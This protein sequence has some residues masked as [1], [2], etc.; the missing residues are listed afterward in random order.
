MAGQATSDFLAK[1]I[2]A[3]NNIVTFRLLSRQLSIH[4]AEAK[5]E[6]EL[7]YDAAKLAKDPVF[8]TYILTGT[9]ALQ[10]KQETSSCGGS[11][12]QVSRRLVVLAGE[13]ELEV[14]KSRFADGPSQ[15]VYSLSPVPLKDHGLLT[16]VADRVRLLDIQRGQSHAAQVG[17]LLSEE[18]PWSGVS[19]SKSQRATKKDTLAP[20]NAKKIDQALKPKPSIDTAQPVAT[21]DTGR[22]SALNF[23][24]SKKPASESKP[25]EPAPSKTKPPTKK[26]PEEATTK[27]KSSRPEHPKESFKPPST[28]SSKGSAPDPPK[29]AAV[30]GKSKRVLD[31]SDEDEP[32]L[33]RSKPALKRKKNRST[34]DDDEEAVEQRSTTSLRAMM[35]IDDDDVVNGRS[36]REAT[37]EHVPSARETAAAAKAAK[38]EASK[39]VDQKER[40]SRKRVPKGKK[41]VMKT[42][43]VK[44]AKGFL[45]TEDYS[46][47]EDADPA[48]ADKADNTDAQSE[49]D[50]GEDIDVDV[51]GRILPKKPASKPTTSGPKAEPKR[52]HSESSTAKSRKNK[53]NDGS[54]SGQQKL[55][56][57][58]GKK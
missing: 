48:D 14:A 41:R 1:E 36:T 24:G 28:A 20:P 31:S 18:A 32:A 30:G 17:M 25:K 6:L 33:N 7:F 56:S 10:P 8:A 4:V 44:N 42:R 11:A 57:F 2:R 16:S 21:K 50:Y 23:G 53:P 51:S 34:D 39:G 15:H 49:T 13:D 5:K 54:K 22:Q 19:K 26:D 12:E 27:N 38:A 35:D 45:V 9:P 47:Y 58:F 29:T 37:P 40:G 55:A 52:Q 3:S 46:S 43:R